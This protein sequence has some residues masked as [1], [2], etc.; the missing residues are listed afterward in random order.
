MKYALVACLLLV[1]MS[2]LAWKPV[3][4]GAATTPKKGGYSVQLPA[5][6]LY[7][8]NAT[9]VVASRDGP[10]LN[11]IFITLVPHKDAFK[12]IKKSSSADALA[13]D[14]AE[15]YVANLQASA[16]Q[17][18]IDGVAILSTEPAELAGHPAF[19][20]HLRYRAAE[21]ISGAGFEEVTLG[22]PLPAGLLL[23]TY[24]APALHFFPKWQ[25]SFEE[26]LKT[27]SLAQP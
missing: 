22:T 24:S 14:L 18:A 5:G 9:N 23:A 4:P 3:D 6:W 2:A 26:T 8:T 15:S 16:R 12:L 7:D 1:P 21:Q 13:E 20:V 17:L 25:P 19:R 27:I 10:F 11:R